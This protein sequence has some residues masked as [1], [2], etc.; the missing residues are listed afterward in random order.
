MNSRDMAR[1]LLRVM[2][3]AQRTRTPFKVTCLGDSLTSGL[4][5][6][7]LS[8]LL[9][10]EVNRLGFGGKT[11]EFIL[12]RYSEI[13]AEGGILIA[14]AGNNNFD[15]PE[16]VEADVDAIA[17]LHG[18]SAKLLVIGLVNGDYPGRRF[19]E[20]GYQKIVDYNARQVG[21]FDDH[22]L[23]IRA[24]LIAR[25]GGHNPHDVLPKS[26]RKDK[27][28]FNYRGNWLVARIV[29]SRLRLLGL[30]T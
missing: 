14:W 23:D 5:P 4:Y 28:H 2:R 1:G 10:T 8:Y 9:R 21:R 13:P 29:Y 16:K 20:A 18:D 22:F 6:H 3:K 17:S 26:I 11:S 7:F 15:D 30:A 25:V 19:G 27:I 24:A 12:E